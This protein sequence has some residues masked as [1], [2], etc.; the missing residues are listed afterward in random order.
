MGQPVH[1]FLEDFDNPGAAAVAPA[2]APGP[3]WE[4]RIVPPVAIA[5]TPDQL[6][7]AYA[8]GLEAGISEGWTMR[9]TEIAQVRSEAEARFQAAMA[10]F[11]GAVLDQLSTSLTR[12]IEAMCSQ[13]SDQVFDVLLPVLKGA[14]VENGIR[15]LVE[16]LHG[17]IPGSGALSVEFTGPRDIIERVWQL[18]LEREPIA[19]QKLAAEFRITEGESIDARIVCA[20]SVIET[21]LA[22]WIGK[23]TGARV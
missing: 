4:P 6:E 5:E 21:R 11:T 22:D 3:A 7:Q 1:L 8:R 10:D 23:I 13:I 15:A 18:Y 19:S 20:H 16:E 9:E 12:Q 14:L 17:L 2:E